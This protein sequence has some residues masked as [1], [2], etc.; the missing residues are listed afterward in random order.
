MRRT[1]LSHPQMK[2]NLMSER[3]LTHEIWIGA[4]HRIEGGTNRDAADLACFAAEV[5]ARCESTP[6]LNEFLDGRALTA[7]G[8]STL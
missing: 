2:I 7:L 6:A 3:A 1:R 8:G 5:L 4:L